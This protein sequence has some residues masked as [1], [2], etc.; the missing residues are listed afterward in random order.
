MGNWLFESDKMR[1][2]SMFF[3]CKCLILVIFHYIY[4]HALKDLKDMQD[5]LDVEIIF[6]DNIATTLVLL[7]SLEYVFQPTSYFIH[8]W[9]I[10]K[11]ESGIN[12]A[13]TC[14]NRTLTSDSTSN[15]RYLGL[16]ISKCL[17]VNCGTI[18]TFWQ[19][20]VLM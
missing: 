3:Y 17:W 9:K 7:A 20:F 8:L 5:A 18:S 15:V 11:C 6:L 4:R 13:G 14:K 2:W 16:P 10:Q 1:S 12:G 19:K